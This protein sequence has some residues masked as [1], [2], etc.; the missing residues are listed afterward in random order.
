M[1]HKRSAEHLEVN[2]TRGLYYGSCDLSSLAYAREAVNRC[3][4]VVGCAGI[5]GGIGLVAHDPHSYVGKATAMVINLTA[6]RVV[7][8]KVELFGLA[9]PTCSTR[10]ATSR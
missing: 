5:T 1:G 2:D 6:R 3:E 10:R 7:A 4:I 9:R 8:E